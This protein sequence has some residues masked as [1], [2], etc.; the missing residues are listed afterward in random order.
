VDGTAG[1]EGRGLVAA[2]P[3]VLPDVAAVEAR[4]ALAQRTLVLQVRTDG[5]DWTLARDA[6]PRLA[7]SSAALALAKLPGGG[8]PDDAEIVL[9]VIAD[10]LADTGEDLRP[11]W[12]DLA[13]A[14]VLLLPPLD[15]PAALAIDASPGL[16]RSGTPAGG[17]LWRVEPGT[18]SDTAEGASAQDETAQGETAQGET[19]ESEEDREALA[20]RRGAR[21]RVLSEDG[22]VLAAVASAV[23]ENGMDVTGR[24]EDGPQGRMLVLAERAD[25][26]WQ[27]FLDGRRLASHV[28]GDWA[29]AFE[30]PAD[31]G[32]LAVRYREPW[33]PLSDAARVAMLVVAG[34]L[35]LPLPRLKRRRV[36]PPRSSRP[37]GR[38]HIERPSGTTGVAG[39]P[40]GTPEA[41][42]VWL[43]EA[44]AR[45]KARAKEGTSPG[46]RGDDPSGDAVTDLR[47]RPKVTADASG[48][49]GS[50]ER[51]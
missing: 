32:R 42:D 1:P 18:G 25:P 48:A 37:V 33:Q 15:E 21:V 22:Q 35:A 27:A 29:Q 46:E 4:G 38:R 16:V 11:Q 49:P 39:A 5:V 45:A 28:H 24:I 17:L 41:M 19:A 51:S 20:A 7:D 31:G 26:G 9:P 3:D 12:Q 10:L 2:D 6:G 23:P 30:L 13:V 43:A 8:A 36:S 50:Q 40:L 47:D 34:L 44:Q 14:S